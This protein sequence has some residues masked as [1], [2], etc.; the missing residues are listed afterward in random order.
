VGNG[1]TGVGAMRA[2]LIANH[3]VRMPRRFL[4]LASIGFPWSWA[5]FTSAMYRPAWSLHSDL[6]WL[7]VAPR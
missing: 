2:L 6:A 3:S 1:R 5:S 4:M 7:H